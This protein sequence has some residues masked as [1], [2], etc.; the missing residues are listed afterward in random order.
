MA[1]LDEIRSEVGAIAAERDLREDRAFGYWFLEKYED[2]SPEDA[3]TTITDGPWDR[4]RDAVYVDE[5]NRILKIYQFKYSEDLSYVKQ[6]LKDLQAGVVA[7]QERLANIDELDLVLVT[8]ASGDS[9]LY[10]QAEDVERRIKGWLKRHRFTTALRLEVIDLKRFLELSERIYGVDVA[11]RW[12]TKEILEDRSIIGLLDAAGLKNVKDRP[13]LFSFNIRR[14]LGLR[15]GSVSL[16]IKE[17]LENEEKRGDFW[18]LNNGIVCLC[19]DFKESGEEI[20][21]KNLTIV[22]GAQTVST[23]SRFLEENP[24]IEEPIWVV[25][26]VLK[27][28]EDE[29]SRAAE[30]TEASN[31]QTPTSTRDLRATDMVHR[32]IEE[33]LREEF[34]LEYVYKRG[35]RAGRNSVKMKDLAQAYIAFWDELPHISFSRPGQIFAESKYYE[36]VFHPQETEELRRRGD[37]TQK[38]EFLLRRLLPWKIVLK[39]RSVLHEKTRSSPPLP[40]SSGSPAASSDTSRSSEVQSYDKKFRSLTYHMVWVYKRLLEEKI[41]GE[42]LSNVYGKIDEILNRTLDQLSEELIRFFMY[43]RAEIPRCLKSTDAIDHLRNYFEPT[44]QFENIK[45]TVLNI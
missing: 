3:E 45:R 37:P 42:G 11:L 27:V 10:K 8:I 40:Q 43:G 39:T 41:R 5:E 15:R 32:R 34:E 19:T 7:E 30:I 36:S 20:F 22:N 16:K 44:P 29:I 12:R 23:I 4:G 35:Q 24:T 17:T 21:F 26:K 25:A 6:G 18:I 2:L 1:I 38:R 31:T 14:F 13:E 28:A 33:W 9:E